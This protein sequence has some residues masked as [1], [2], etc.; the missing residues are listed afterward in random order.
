MSILSKYFLQLRLILYREVSILYFREYDK[1]KHELS[2]TSPLKESVK[3]A[4]SD[5]DSTKS[6]STLM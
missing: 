1:E 4:M 2:A 6:N 5:F 3:E